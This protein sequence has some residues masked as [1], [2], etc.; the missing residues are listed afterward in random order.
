MGLFDI[1]SA[2]VA[3]TVGAIATLAA[4]VAAPAVAAVAVGA[5]VV[6]ASGAVTK[7]CAE[8]TKE[9]MNSVLNSVS[10][11]MPNN[12]TLKSVTGTS[13]SAVMRYY[14]TG[15]IRSTVTLKLTLS[16]SSAEPKYEAQSLANSAAQALRSTFGSNVTVN[17]TNYGYEVVAKAGQSVF[18]DEHI[19]VY[20]RAPQGKFYY[21]GE[22]PRGLDLY[23]VAAVIDGFTG[24]LKGLKVGKASLGAEQFEL[25]LQRCDCCESIGTAIGCPFY[26]V[27]YWL[28]LEGGWSSSSVCYPPRR[29]V[30]AKGY[31][32]RADENLTAY[33][34]ID[35][36][37]PVKE[38]DVVKVYVFSS[39]FLRQLKKVCAA[40][41]DSPEC[42]ELSAF[43]SETCDSGFYLVPRFFEQVLKSFGYYNSKVLEFAEAVANGGYLAYK[44]DVIITDVT[45]EVDDTSLVVCKKV[46]YLTGDTIEG[47]ETDCYSFDLTGDVDV[48]IDTLTP[49]GPADEVIIKSPVPYAL[50]MESGS[51]YVLLNPAGVAVPDP[52]VTSKLAAV[53]T[54]K[55]IVLKIGTCW[56]LAYLPE[57]E[58]AF[59]VVNS[60]GSK[61]TVTYSKETKSASASL[62]IE[63][64]GEVPSTAASVLNGLLNFVAMQA[65]KGGLVIYSPY[66]P[67]VFLNALLMKLRAKGG[68]TECVKIP[69]ASKC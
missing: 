9:A 51:D 26:T 66:L 3:V 27:G 32:V 18:G 43:L 67:L 5:A 34:N 64:K 56:F 38:G 52:S 55:G 16:V 41:G 23:V 53:A 12:L 33:V 45:Y 21:F 47:F 20:V 29:I 39:A 54:D 58:F 25:A 62:G 35:V 1:V 59:A 8:K 37:G 60:Y 30:L 57:Y 14:S 68:G 24:A 42:K 13:A 17:K 49:E 40:N 10:V 50:Y 48:D 19:K 69:D 22:D 46:P 36:D 11:K 28:G 4:G 7:D 15:A 31:A 44:G 61:L 2:A 65:A 63:G 6:G